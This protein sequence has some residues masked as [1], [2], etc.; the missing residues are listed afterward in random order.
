MSFLG[1]IFQ[2]GLI[3]DQLNNTLNS[4]VT[5]IGSWTICGYVW[6]YKQRYLLSPRPHAHFLVH[7]V[8]FLP[9]AYLA[10]ICLWTAQWWA[11]PAWV[12]ERQRPTHRIQTEGGSSWNPLPQQRKL[13]DA[14][15]LFE[16][17]LSEGSLRVVL[18]SLARIA[19][20]EVNNYFLHQ[21]RALTLIWGHL[22]P[23]I[24]W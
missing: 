16:P 15:A 13:A 14:P 23:V 3:V 11:C 22:T 4:N 18:N 6:V 9:S 19:I 7:I 8:N 17:P 5:T 21:M 12:G 10:L 2:N 24:R 1:Q 20:T